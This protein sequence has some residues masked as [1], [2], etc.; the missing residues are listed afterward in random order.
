MAR[1]SLRQVRNY[2]NQEAFMLKSDFFRALIISFAALVL[3]ACGSESTT[4]ESQS[5][6]D[7]GKTYNWK[8]VTTWPPGFPVLQEGAERF[9]DTI[10]GKFNC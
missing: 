10:K 9:A 5:N 1:F 7:T 4:S 2:L 8:M 6:I 3:A